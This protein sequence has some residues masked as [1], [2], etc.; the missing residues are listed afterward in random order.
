VGRPTSGKVLHSWLLLHDYHF[1]NASTSK[2]NIRSEVALTDLGGGRLWGSAYYLPSHS[3]SGIRCKLTH[4]QRLGVI[5]LQCGR[6]LWTVSARLCVRFG[7]LEE[8]FMSYKPH[9][10]WRTMEVLEE[11]A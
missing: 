10:A 8:V 3:A 6:L 11:L 2:L 7:A 9:G 4:I 5:C 1:G